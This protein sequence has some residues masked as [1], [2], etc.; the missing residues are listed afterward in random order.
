MCWSI[1]LS[2]ESN[3]SYHLSVPGGSTSKDVCSVVR[4]IGDELGRS[5]GCSLSSGKI[6]PNAPAEDVHSY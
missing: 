6:G 2:F 1:E 3:G 5:L 4:V